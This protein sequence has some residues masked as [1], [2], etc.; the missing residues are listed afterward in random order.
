MI[1]VNATARSQLR[2]SP[3]PSSKP[4]RSGFRS[5]EL[6]L[7]LLAGCSCLMTLLYHPVVEALQAPAAIA[8]LSAMTS[9]EG[10]YCPWT[11]LAIPLP[12]ERE[13]LLKEF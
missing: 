7:V 3:R 4:R 6:D 2:R 12:P 5:Q 13:T 10:K 11:N 9:V 1:L 8:P